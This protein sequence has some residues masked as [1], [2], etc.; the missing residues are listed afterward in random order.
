MKK[1]LLS[2]LLVAAFMPLALA[3]DNT[4]R[5]MNYTDIAACRTYTWP[6]NNQTYTSDTVVTYIDS[7]DDIIY[8]LNLTVNHPFISNETYNGTRCS[9]TW[10]GTEY[11]FSSD[12]SDTVVAA[13]G[14]GLCDSIFNLHLILANTETD[15]D[16]VHTCGQYIWFG[17]TLS[18][19]GDY[20]DS[21]YN[22]S[23]GCMHYNRLNLSIVTTINASHQVANC[24]DYHWFDTVLTTSGTYT[25]FYQDT[26]SGCDTIH[27]LTLTILVD[28]ARVTIDSAC[29][30]RTWRGQTFN[31]TGYYY[32]MDT[33][34][35][36]HCVT[37]HPL[38]LTIK[39]P[40]ANTADTAL[41]GCNGVLFTVSSRAGTT[42]MTFRESTV[43]D[44]LF[45][46]HS[47]A[48]C[49]D[50]TIHLNVTINKSGYDT[51]T[52]H[53]CDSFYW[54]MNE[55][56]YYTTPA[57]APRFTS[58]SD[59]NGC[60]SVHI[61]SLTINK[62]P[63][64]TAINGDWYLNA[65]ETAVLYP[66]CTEGATYKWTY[67]NQTSTADTLRIPNVQGNID[68]SLQAT[69]TYPA[70]GISCSDTSWITIV[71]FVGIDGVEGTNV[72]LYPNPTAGQLN[73]QSQEAVREV[74]IFNALGQQVASQQ[75]LGNQSV[76]N[77]S[78]LSKG[79]YTMRL[80][81][82]NGQTLNRKFI[83]TK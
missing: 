7:T 38:D 62:S 83:I 51:T 39:T 18:E 11:Q 63:E 60:D 69:I 19:S 4:Q 17:D 79:S 67:G 36:T 29:A 76:M 8:V 70:N 10:R 48:R 68:V 26:L 80:T 47:W 2:L 28:T 16:T 22:P 73:I 33:N 44:T 53:S 31:A 81:L 20:T 66:T 58:G 15:Y 21:I 1:A 64:I 24:G 77:L 14:S 27:T 25:H 50:S 43:W 23:I 56:T 37:A 52:V 49:Y 9:Y 59:S 57:T 46:D 75:N 30:T 61:L 82:E 65:G 3:Q 12:Y 35:T 40:R 71:T 42:N 78:N 74:V 6:V 5:T 72:T 55:R 54:A 34:A 32:V 45:F 41:T 13:S